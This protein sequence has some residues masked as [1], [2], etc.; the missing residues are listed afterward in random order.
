MNALQKT[1]L[2]AL[3]VLAAG[4]CEDFVPVPKPRAYPRVIFP[5]KAYRNFD[6][7]YCGFTF[8]MP[9]YAVVERDT[10][11]FEKKPESDCWFNIEVPSL[12]AQI[13]CSYY[14]VTGRTR[15]DELVADAFTM[16]QKHNIKANYIEEIPVHR[17]A[18]RVHGVIFSI[19]GAT[20]SSYQFFATDSTKHFL[21]GALYFR[22][23]S[24]PDSIAP[25]LAFM[26]QDVNKMIATL[27]WGE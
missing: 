12:N 7:S 18:E 25:V 6:E 14:P 16:A 22:T 11:F 19:E 13:H 23:Q 26:R 17:T 27:K 5:E 10:T 21:R 24:R 9:R 1:G 8:E 15:L 20:A 3:L 2:W 4:G